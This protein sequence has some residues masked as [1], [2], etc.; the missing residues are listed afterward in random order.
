[1]AS[2][3][4]LKLDVEPESDYRA[5]AI[6]C[7]ER[8]VELMEA[9]IRRKRV[10]F[11]LAHK[12]HIRFFLYDRP[13]DSCLS[14]DM[15]T[16]LSTAAAPSHGFRL[17]YRFCRTSSASLGLPHPP[18]ASIVDGYTLLLLREGGPGKANVYR[19]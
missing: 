10:M 9:S 19:A 12:T 4:E 18:V 14:T 11:F 15:E 16:L 6:Q 5:V 8:V 7:S 1:M 17:F 13:F 3:G 2:F